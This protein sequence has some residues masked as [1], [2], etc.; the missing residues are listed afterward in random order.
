ME[1]RETRV[2]GVHSEVHRAR[3][4]GFWVLSTKHG[5]NHT[6]FCPRLLN[7][8]LSLSKKFGEFW[9]Y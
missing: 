1:L 8:I 6:K 9:D 5:S 7:I 2:F 4:L 3:G